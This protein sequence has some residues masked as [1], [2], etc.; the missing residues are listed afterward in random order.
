LISSAL[1]RQSITELAR[2]FNARVVDVSLE[3]VIIELS[4]KPDRVDAFVELLKPFG[5]LEAAR[6]GTMAMPRAVMEGLSQK[7]T[8]DQADAVDLSSLPPG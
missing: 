4:A 1:Q 3:S 6:S 8:I 7:E 2:L 5:I